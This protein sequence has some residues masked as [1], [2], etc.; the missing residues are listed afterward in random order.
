[1]RPAIESVESI[2]A[3]S[4][5]HLQ[6]LVQEHIDRLGPCC[7]LNHLDVSRVTIMDGLFQN[8]AFNGDISTWNTNKVVTAM[9]MFEGSAFD[10]DIS[11]W[12]M[13]ALKFANNMFR[14]AQFT[15]DISNW[16]FATPGPGN[17]SGAFYSEHFRSDMPLLKTFGCQKAALHPAYTGSFRDEYTLAMATQLFEKESALKTYLAHSASQGLHRLHAEYLIDVHMHALLQNRSAK[18]PEWCPKEVF[19]QMKNEK[20]IGV[21][22]G[23]N[24]F[25][26]YAVAYQR[27]K[28]LDCPM[29]SIDSEV[30][31]AP[32]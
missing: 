5:Q 2:P 17:L 24:M 15:G 22:L 10:G 27:L 30:F 4:A 12:R 18:K 29:P 6:Q 3:T 8:S 28:T 11:L 16:T 25:D 7:D 14:D 31:T 32:Q 1:M 19:E 26:I 21:G 20:E 23:L 13:P 9:G